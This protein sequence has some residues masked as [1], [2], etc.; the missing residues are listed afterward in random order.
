M[1][2]KM[3][4]WNEVSAE[5]RGRGKGGGD[6]QTDG[7]SQDEDEREEEDGREAGH[8]DDEDRCRGVMRARREGGKRWGQTREG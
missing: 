5:M 8:V 6:V 3:Q 1:I 2:H 7:R 4:G